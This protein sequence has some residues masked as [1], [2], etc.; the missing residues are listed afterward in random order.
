MEAIVAPLLSA[1]IAAAPGLLALLTGKASDEEAKA[2]A[3]ATL[4]GL[5][6]IDVDGIIAR[7]RRQAEPTQPIVLGRVPL[8]PRAGSVNRIDFGDD[9][10]GG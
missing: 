1:L 3:L 10:G 2:H 5:R 8:A 7:E 9:E 6:V 4:A